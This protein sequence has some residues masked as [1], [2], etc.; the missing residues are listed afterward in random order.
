MGW[1]KKAFGI[2]TPSFIKKI[3]DNV[4]AVGSNIEDEIR[5]AGSTIEDK[6]KQETM[7]ANIGSVNMP[8]LSNVAE[9]MGLGGSGGGG[10]EMP[11]PPPDKKEAEL[12]A[13]RKISS[14]R[15]NIARSRSVFTTPTGLTGQARTINNFLTGQ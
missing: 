1:V 15:K 7:F 14:R 9:M 4:K 5:S 10:E 3:E 11:P 13:Q 12:K 2:K 8:S 6:W